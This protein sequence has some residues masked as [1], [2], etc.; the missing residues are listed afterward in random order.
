MFNRRIDTQGGIW[1]RRSVHRTTLGNYFAIVASITRSTLSQL[2]KRYTL[3]TFVDPRM[4]WQTLSLFRHGHDF[5][6]GDVEWNVGFS[7]ASSTYLPSEWIFTVSLFAESIHQLS[8]EIPNH[9]STVYIWVVCR[10]L[11]SGGNST[12]KIINSECHSHEYSSFLCFV[13]PGS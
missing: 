3:K 5:K 12:N 11:H 4:K 9:L 8:H 7:R 10:P 1:R 6:K 2:W 13:I